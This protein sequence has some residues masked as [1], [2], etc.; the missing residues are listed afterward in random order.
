MRSRFKPAKEQRV[1]VR[2]QLARLL[3]PA[4]V[5]ATLRPVLPPGFKPDDAI[6]AVQG[7]HPDRFVLRVQARSRAGQERSFALKVYSDDFGERVWE[8]AQ[9]VAQHHAPNGHG[10]C[11]P[12]AYLAHERMLVFPWVDGLFLSEIVDERKP[13]L[14]RIAARLAAE[15]HCLPIVPEPP[16]TAQVFVEEARGRC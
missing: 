11:L 14:L 2:G 16:T 8:F 7:V 4:V 12:T 1:A 3:Q 9:T 13:E 5:L 10:F 6:C 15:L